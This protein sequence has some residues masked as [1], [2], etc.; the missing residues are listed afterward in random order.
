MT[1]LIAASPA[2]GAVLAAMHHAAFPPGERWNAE[3]FAQQL[4]LPGTFGWIAGQDGFILARVAADESEILT[5]AVLPTSQRRGIAS[6]LLRAAQRTA[7]EAGALAM[8]LEV[9]EPNAAARGL[10][11]SFGFAEVGRRRR[12]YTGGIDALVLR[13]ELS[14]PAQPQ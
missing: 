9:A 10:Y 14:G 13:A 3:A 11:A 5:L 8:L 7:A 6:S 4:C 12:Y 2:H 1:A